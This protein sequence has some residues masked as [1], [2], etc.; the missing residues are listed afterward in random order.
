MTTHRLLLSLATLLTLSLFAPPSHAADKLNA[1]IIDGQNNHD[2]KAC[3]P[4]LKSI[5]QDS[6]RFTVTVSTAPSQSP[7]KNPDAWANY[8]PKFADYDVLIFNY[9]GDLW[10]Q[11]LRTNFTNYVRNGGGLVIVHAADNSFPDW[12]EFN[13]M[14]AVGGWGG[15][16]EKSGPMIRYRD[17]KIVFDTSPGDGGT[18]GAQ[19][20]FLLESREPNHPVM[21]GLPQA[22][23]HAPDELYAKLRGPCKNVTV[24]ATAFSDPKTGGTNEN[25]PILLVIDF[26]KGRVFHT[27]IGHG[28]EAMSSLAFQITLQRGSEFAATAKVTLPAPNPADLPADKP[29]L[30]NFK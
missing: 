27:V 28:P 29:V 30:R 4:I 6:G 11:T 26:G 22:F 13:E 12:P 9:N 3:T 16:N 7:Q 5:L 8:N 21:K 20:P 25:E 15:R 18:H 23:R 1:L 10:P 14:I 24:L 19:H 17:G 2:W